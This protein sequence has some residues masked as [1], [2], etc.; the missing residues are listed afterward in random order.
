MTSSKNH[1]DPSFFLHIWTTIE[2]V[3]PKAT[4]AR[5]WHGLEGWPV[6]EVMTWV[7]CDEVVCDN[8]CY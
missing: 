6:A 3:V 7:G 4:G 8:T 5:G 1:L 2:I